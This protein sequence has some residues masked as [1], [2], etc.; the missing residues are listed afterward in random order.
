[1]TKKC[2]FCQKKFTEFEEQVPLIIVLQD[3][4]K[5]KTASHNSCRDQMKILE[6]FRKDMK[7]K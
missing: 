1:M 4:V 6:D 7:L 3:G 2:W 5:H